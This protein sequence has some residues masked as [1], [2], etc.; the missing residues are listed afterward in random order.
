MDILRFVDQISVPPTA[1]TTRLDLNDGEIWGLQYEGTDFSPPPLKSAWAG[2][3]LTDGEQLAA[4]AYANRRIRLSLDLIGADADAVA[5]HLQELWRELDRPSNFLL[6][7]PDGSDESMYLR[8]IRSSETTVTDYPGDGRLRTVEVGIVAEPFAYGPKVELDQVRVYADPAAVSNG[9]YLDVVDPR[10]DVETP[11]FLRIEQ[12]TIADFAESVIGVRRRG[13]PSS[14]PIVLQAE[15]MTPG[16]DT[17]LGASN[18]AWYSGAGQNYLRTTF[19]TLPGL[20]ARAT[21]TAWP[22]AGVDARGT[23][24]VFLR[25][26]ATAGSTTFRLQVSIS[27][28]A[29][30]IVTPTLQPTGTVDYIDMGLI[31]LPPGGDPVTDGYSGTELSVQSTSVELR[32]AR[33]SGAGDLDWDLLLLVPADDRLCVISWPVDAT[34]TALVLDSARTMV[35]ALGSGGEVRATGQVT[36]AGL[37]PMVSPG[38]TNRVVILQ[39][40]HRRQNDVVNRLGDWFDVTPY[41]WPRY[42]HVAAA[43]S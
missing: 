42:L 11:L 25:V 26:R 21:M 24:R 31:Q 28:V 33:D 32:A 15:S 6:W 5:G 9:C 37:P 29:T 35:Y 16:T 23:Y 14:M 13:A 39:D 43:G 7:Q 40:T 38:Q 20:G 4:S 22:P 27:G 19:A 12:G 34:L 41:Y 18:D 30:D 36:I 10:G 3:L 8:T 2:T 1:P 17:T